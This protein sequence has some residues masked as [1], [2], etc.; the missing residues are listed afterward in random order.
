M[1]PHLSLAVHL[2]LHYEEM[3]PQ[4]RAYLANLAAHPYDLYVT[5]TRENEALKRSI[6]EIQPRA[7]IWCTENR[8]Y[9]IGPFIDFLH[10]V[11][12]GAYDVVMKLHSKN[13]GE[14]PSTVIN[15]RRVTRAWWSRLLLESMLGTAE[16]V[17]RNLAIFAAEPQVGMLGSTHLV[18][19]DKAHM[20]KVQELLPAMMERLGHKE[21][22]FGFVV[23][24][25]FMVRSSILQRVKDAYKVG[26]FP[27]TDGRLTDGTPAHA[28]ERG[29][30]CLTL[31][32]G[33]TLRGVGYNLR[34][35]LAALRTGLCRFLWRVK[36]TDKGHRVIKLCKIP[37][38]YSKSPR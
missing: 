20:E 34:F 30:G 24:T 6:K 22:E 35:E 18:T 7:E 31:A 4:L 23:G 2:H 33:Y 12:L 27:P 10:R 5:L 17:K 11:D 3:W 21:W 29:L 14:G 15:H 38:Y 26:D 19:R 32:E 8:G 36:R 1:P 16:R 37:I 13:A 9:D 25:M 28:L